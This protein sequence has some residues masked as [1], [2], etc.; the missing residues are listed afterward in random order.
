MTSE[1]L[2]PAGTQGGSGRPEGDGELEGGL[3]GG[4]CPRS[5]HQH[6]PDVVDREGIAE[7]QGFPSDMS[8][9]RLLMSAVWTPGRSRARVRGPCGGSE[10]PGPGCPSWRLCRVLLVLWFNAGSGASSPRVGLLHEGGVLLAR[11]CPYCTNP[12]TSWSTPESCPVAPDPRA[13]HAR[14]HPSNRTCPCR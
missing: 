8:T 5:G 11:G 1:A 6:R 3:A 2:A 9:V 12:R 7:F 13:V 14:D 4:R 10:H